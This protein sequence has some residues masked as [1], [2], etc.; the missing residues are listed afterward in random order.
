M[1]HQRLLHLGSKLIALG[2]DFLAAMRGQDRPDQSAITG[3]HS[4]VRVTQPLPYRGR[5]LD[6]GEQEREHRRGH[7][8]K[9]SHQG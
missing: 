2:V 1:P 8:P 7:Q 5:T 4:R 9:A 3:Q 6:V